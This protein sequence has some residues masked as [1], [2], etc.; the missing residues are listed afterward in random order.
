PAWRKVKLTICRTLD[1]SSTDNTLFIHGS[2]LLLACQLVLPS[3]VGFARLRTVPRHFRE[4]PR[5][6]VAKTRRLK[7]LEAPGVPSRW[8]KTTRRS[9]QRSVS[10]FAGAH[11]PIHFQPGTEPYQFVSASG[12]SILSRRG[13]APP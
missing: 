11:R 12:Q 1:E 13:G 10:R 3:P 5:V 6:R 4:N 7:R 8:C 9:L 2:D